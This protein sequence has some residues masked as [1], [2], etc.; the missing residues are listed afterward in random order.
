MILFTKGIDESVIKHNTPH[1]MLN[2][3]I[4]IFQVMKPLMKNSWQRQ[5]KFSNEQETML[6]IFIKIVS[7]YLKIGRQ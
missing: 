5:V 4:F 7:N 2:Q 3:I 1:I 6:N